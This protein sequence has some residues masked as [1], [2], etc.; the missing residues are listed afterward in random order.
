MNLNKAKWEFRYQISI[1]IFTYSTSWTLCTKSVC[2]RVRQPSKQISKFPCSSFSLKR[3][4]VHKEETMSSLLPTKTA[5]LSHL[6]FNHVCFQ[7]IFPVPSKKDAQNLFHGTLLLH[8]YQL[9]H[10]SQNNPIQAVT[11]FRGTEIYAT[12]ILFCN[13]FR[14]NNEG[15]HQRYPSFTHL[16]TWSNMI[17]MKN[18]FKYKS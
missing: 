10:K 5:L 3:V 17:L 1:Y 15:R 11:T 7:N 18:T 6:P 8:Q 12:K 16:W 9:V 4:C 2:K 13:E 14:D